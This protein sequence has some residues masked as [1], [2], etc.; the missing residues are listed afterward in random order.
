[1]KKWVTTNKY[2]I[3]HGF[4]SEDRSIEN[5]NWQNWT[6]YISNEVLD[7]KLNVLIEWLNAEQYSIKAIYPIQRSYSSAYLR[8]GPMGGGG[9]FGQGAGYAFTQ[10]M[11][12]IVLAEKEEYLTDEEYAQRVTARENLKKLEAQKLANTEKTTS[13]SQQ[14]AT[15]REELEKVNSK[16]ISLEN[17][18]IKEETKKSFLKTITIFKIGTLEKEHDSRSTA[19]YHQKKLLEDREQLL[20]EKQQL[21]EKIEAISSALSQLSQ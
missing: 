12:F 6:Y 8:C 5:S 13:F 9:G 21:E 20:I 16:C 14:L 11:G 1:M 4:E 3:L 19:E 7:E 17:L 2:K 10:N 15:L 18:D